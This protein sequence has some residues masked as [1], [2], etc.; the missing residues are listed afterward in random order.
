M[1]VNWF[2]LYSYRGLLSISFY[3]LDSSTSAITVVNAFYLEV[4][5]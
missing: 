4:L 3:V 1:G 2:R 5:S